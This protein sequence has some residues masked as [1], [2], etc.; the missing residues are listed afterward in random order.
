MLMRL[1]TLSHYPFSRTNIA[2]TWAKSSKRAALSL[3][4]ML[5]STNLWRTGSLPGSNSTRNP[6][7]MIVGHTN[8]YT[9]ELAVLDRLLEPSTSAL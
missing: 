8:P 3:P 5:S 1:R 2:M 6:L 4:L 9:S 7:N